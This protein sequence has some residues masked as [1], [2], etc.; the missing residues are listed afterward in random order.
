MHE[1][2]TNG[3]LNFIIAV[4]GGLFLLV[5]WGGFYFFVRFKKRDDARREKFTD[6][7]KKS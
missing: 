7:Q 5:M 3:Q 4:F 1:T 6:G 2:I